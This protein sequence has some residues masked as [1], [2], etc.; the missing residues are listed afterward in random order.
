M[1]C[2]CSEGCV[3]YVCAACSAAWGVGVSCSL[4]SPW[5]VSDLLTLFLKVC[6]LA[7]L[8]TIYCPS[9]H[10]SHLHRDWSALQTPSC[11]VLWPWLCA[12]GPSKPHLLPLLRLHTTTCGH[13]A[14][15]HK[16]SCNIQRLEVHKNKDLR[17]LR[18]DGVWRVDPL[19]QLQ[20]GSPAA[21]GG[22]KS[23]PS[24]AHCLPPYTSSWKQ[25]GEMDP[26]WILWP[27]CDCSRHFACRGEK[28]EGRLGEIEIKSLCNSSQVQCK[29]DTTSLP[30]QHVLFLPLKLLQSEISFTSRFTHKATLYM[31]THL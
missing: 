22:W 12:T 30:G 2:E 1:E 11:E 15:K 19:F 20:P 7:A 25:I 16:G 26:W 31:S 17:G 29:S 10:A 5:C 3:S 6:S 28:G 4:E 8:V 27:W 13:I 23:T 14:G 24:A 21:S 9:Q 18:T